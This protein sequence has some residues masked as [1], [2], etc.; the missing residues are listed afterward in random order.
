MLLCLVL[1][2]I[3]LSSV[4]STV[5]C[6]TEPSITTVV[7]VLIPDP[8]SKGETPSYSL[9]TYDS[10]VWLSLS[11]LMLVSAL[12]FH[13]QFHGSVDVLFPAV[14]VVVT[15]YLLS[16]NIC[17]N[18]ALYSWPLFRISADV[19]SVLIES[20]ESFGKRLVVILKFLKRGRRVAIAAAEIAMAGST[21]DHLARLM[22]NHE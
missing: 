20:S 19:R 2:G 3:L 18:S 9:F 22:P 10:S 4:S 12:F 6:Y 8:Q 1:I 5:T 21:M 7:V 14:I 17:A 13:I 11:F 15:P 16:P